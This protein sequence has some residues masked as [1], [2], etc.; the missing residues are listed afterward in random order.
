MNKQVFA[1]KGNAIPDRLPPLPAVIKKNSPNI[2]KD[3]TFINLQ[4]IA[5]QFI[6]KNIYDDSATRLRLSRKLRLF[7]A[8]FIA[9]VIKLFADHVN[10]DSGFFLSSKDRF[11]IALIL[12]VPEQTILLVEKHLHQ[13]KVFARN[14]SLSEFLNKLIYENIRRE[15]ATKAPKLPPRYDPTS[16]GSLSGQQ[17][18]NDIR[19]NIIKFEVLE[20]KKGGFLKTLPGVAF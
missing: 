13:K 7:K 16:A 11:A 17:Q 10:I 15:D 9:K 3:P 4:K 18:Q 1:D 2:F 20:Q 14:V 8:N 6:D 5:V 12:R 19:Y